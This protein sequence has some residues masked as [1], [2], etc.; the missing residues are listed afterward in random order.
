MKGFLQTTGLGVQMDSIQQ[1]AER[2]L[3]RDPQ[4]MHKQVEEQLAR[5]SG[6]TAAKLQQS[7]EEFKQGV[8]EFDTVVTEESSKHPQQ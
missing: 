3:Q 1:Y 8:R 7:A 2:M 6:A 4:G 5:K